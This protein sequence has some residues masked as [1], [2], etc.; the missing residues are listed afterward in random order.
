MVNKIYSYDSNIYSFCYSSS[1]HLSSPFT[2]EEI[3]GGKVSIDLNDAG[4][5]IQDEIDVCKALQFINLSCPLKS[6]NNTVTASAEIPFAVA[7]RMSSF[8]K[9]QYC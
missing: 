6:G 5:P 1:S 2:A 4:I 9:W 8:V 7:V 3:T